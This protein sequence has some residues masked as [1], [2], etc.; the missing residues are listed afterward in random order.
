MITV[1]DSAR[2]R[3]FSL[4]RELGQR[5]SRRLFEDISRHPIALAERRA[6]PRSWS[7]RIAYALA[8]A[9]YA[10]SVLVGVGGV[11][12]L[13][14]PWENILVVLLGVLLLL[15]CLVARPTP[16][17]PPYFLLSRSEYPT[18]HRLADLIA[19]RMGAPVVD[20]IA[21]SAD[22]GANYRVAGWRRRRYIEFGSPL[23]A[24][25]STE[26]RVAIL[27][28][29]LSH[30]AN[31]DPLRGLLLFG[32][33]NTLSSWASALR[34]TSI[35]RP[36]DGM[37]Q[38][39]TGSLASIMAA[40][41]QLLML[42]VSE[43]MFWAVKGLLLLVLRQSQRAE[44][45]ADML[46]ATVAGSKEMQRALEKTYLLEVVDGAMKSYVL[47]RSTGPI[48]AKLSDAVQSLSEDDLERFRTESRASNWQVDSTHPPTA[49]RVDLLAKQVQY[50]PSDLMSADDVAALVHEVSR[51]VASTQRELINRSREAIY[52]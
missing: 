16:P 29:E 32:S 25:L 6:P 9:V 2:E 50:P 24:I 46:A 38:L 1:V 44:Y 47:E 28:H 15:M 41:F 11:V 37:V 20:G 18:L 39:P 12:L 5:F 49:M 4:Q 26:E 22:F 31:G 34:P 27:A 23:L 45:L 33:V 14:P 8:I 48:E 52:G 36:V 35:G 51:L 43:M 13:L 3:W 19:Q 21:I 7:L 30:G 10:A 17:E 42:A 40:P